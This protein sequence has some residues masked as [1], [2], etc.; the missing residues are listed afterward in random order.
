MARDP[1]LAART[2]PKRLGVA[3]RPVQRLPR[4]LDG[5]TRRRGGRLA[6]LHV[7]H[8]MPGGL[9]TRRRRDDIHDHEGWNIAAR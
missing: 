6:D 3:Q 8:V 5:G 1:G 4:R 2:K 7:N 9:H